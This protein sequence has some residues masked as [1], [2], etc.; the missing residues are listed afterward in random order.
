MWDT[1]GTI[2]QQAEPGHLQKRDGPHENLPTEEQA[3]DPD[4]ERPARI[5]QA[6]CGRAHIL[7]HA[8]AE[9]VEQ[10]DRDCNNDT[11]VEHAG[12]VDELVP[13]AYEVEPPSGRRRRG[14]LDEGKEGHENEN[15]DCAEQALVADGEKGRNTISSQYPLFNDKLAGRTEKQGMLDIHKSTIGY[16]RSQDLSK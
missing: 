16:H 2:D 14:K 12:R 4:C 10:G 11:R 7:G 8:Q 15:G 13:A 3:D 6:P 9:K 1:H 5:R